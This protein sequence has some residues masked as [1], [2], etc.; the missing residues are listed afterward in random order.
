MSKL[1]ERDFESFAFVRVTMVA[2][3]FLSYGF[4]SPFSIKLIIYYYPLIDFFFFRNKGV[5]E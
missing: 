5:I 1:R 2:L 3:L 4:P